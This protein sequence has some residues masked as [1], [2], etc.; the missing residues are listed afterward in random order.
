MLKTTEGNPLQ[1]RAAFVC[2]GRELSRVATRVP[3]LASG[4]NAAAL[5]SNS[6]G[7]AT[8]EREQCG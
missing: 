1:L 4:R 8:G 7:A 5:G 3:A 6:H 2:K